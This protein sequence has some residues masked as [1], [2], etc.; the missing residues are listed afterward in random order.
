MVG[1]SLFGTL[2]EF[3]PDDRRGRRR[4]LRLLLLGHVVEIFELS[5]ACGYVFSRGQDR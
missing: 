3:P 5:S 4:Y 1:V 2:G